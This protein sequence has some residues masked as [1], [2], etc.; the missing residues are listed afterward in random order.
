EDGIRDFHV[1][2]VQTCALPISV[3]QPRSWMYRLSS[4]VLRNIGSR[5]FSRVPCSG[6]L[7]EA[8]MPVVSSTSQGNLRGRSGAGPGRCSRVV[9]G[10]KP[11]HEPAN[12]L[13]EADPWRETG[14]SLEIGGI[15][16]GAQYVAWLQGLEFDPGL[17]AQMAFQGGDIL[18]Q[19]HR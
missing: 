9:V 15:R 1:T 3:I 10:A 14:D 4:I 11:L 8:V 19:L 6:L 2:G 13:V 16:A 17:A 5:R 18:Q 7:C 12:S